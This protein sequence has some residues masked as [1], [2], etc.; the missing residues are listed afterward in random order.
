MLIAIH[1]VDKP[2]MDETRNRFRPE[3]LAYLERYA[4]RLVTAG[5][6]LDDGGRQIGSF[7]LVDFPDMDAAMAFH[8]EDPFVREGV[9]SDS[10]VHRYDAKLG[11]DLA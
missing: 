6:L 8:E 10:R 5:P 3:R 4:A 9:Y 2:G 11:K 7:A 1:S